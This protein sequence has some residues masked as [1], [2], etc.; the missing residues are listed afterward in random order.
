MKHFLF[1]IFFLAIVF[2]V[3]AQSV[4]ITQ[5]NG[6]EVL[7]GCQNYQIQWNA[8]GVTNN[9]NI[10]YSLNN[11]AIW[12]SVA[13][14][15]NVLPLSSTYSYDWSVPMVSSN[16]VLVRIRDYSDTL[17]QDVSNAVFTIQLPITVTSPSGGESWQGLSNQTI[18]WNPAGTSGFF[19]LYYSVNNGSSWNTIVSNIAANNYNWTVPNTPSTQ[20]LVRV[21]DATTSCQLGISNATFEISAAQP[22]LTSPNGGETWP[23]NASR[24]ITWTP[25]TFHSTV[26]LEY[27]TDNGSSFNLIT[28]STTNDGSH[29]WII[30]N[31]PSG[32]VLVRASNTSGSTVFDE[33][34]A[35]FTIEYPHPILTSPNGGQIWRSGNT[36]TITWDNSLISSSVKLEYSRDNG[37]TWATIT[38]STSNTGTYSWTIPKFATTT[39]ALVRL[40]NT[41]VSSI[42]D[43][44]DAVFT[45][46]APITVDYPV[47]V[48]DTLT[49]CS[50]FN[51]SFSKTGAFE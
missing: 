50:T 9:W 44:S 34:D 38:N 18:S 29:P 48:N 13:S 21:T 33:S 42:T 15:L 32:Q 47:D 31:A 51:V 14:N 16:T 10:D 30:P 35:V 26:K 28:N 2:S 5:P 7:Y 49:S 40:T 41:V 46:K 11:G 39:E 25:S 43:T 12:T 19:D 6:G 17:K 8:T 27:S 23:I 24:N 3:E 36:Q 1:S 45:I 37:S 4:V 20:A 22:I